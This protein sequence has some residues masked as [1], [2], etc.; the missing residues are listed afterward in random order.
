MSLLAGAVVT[1]AMEDPP[2]DPIKIRVYL[3]E[4]PDPTD[5]ESL[6]RDTSAAAGVAVPSWKIEA[7]PDVD[8]VA[9]S[10]ADL[11]PVTA[12]RF[13]IYG[14]HV[15][16]APPFGKI[17]LRIEANAAFGTGRHE[18][19][20]GCLMALSDLA[21]FKQP[22]RILDMG[23]GSGILAMAAASLWPGRVIAVDNDPVAVAVARENAM[24]NRLGRRIGLGV[25]EGYKSG[26]VH[27]GGP[28]DLIIA[29][30]LA[31]P[32]CEMAVPLWHHLEQGGTAI[33][34][35]LLRSQEAM[36]LTRHR[37]L[38]LRLVRRYTLGDWAILVLRR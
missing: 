16:E 31:Q 25:S 24:I 27:A 6:L 10:Q 2:P 30:I 19:T 32:L 23:C 8:W 28:Y 22:L 17:S 21:K 13:Y 34:S 1:D 7:L 33:L 11:P 4:A 12:G 14:A 3:E 38:G 35:G 5:L 26:L 20:S 15:T 37:A 36:V 9:K 29:N 18:T